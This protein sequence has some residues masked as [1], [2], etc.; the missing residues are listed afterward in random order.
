PFPGTTPLQLAM[1]HT[2][3]PPVLDPLPGPER[4]AIA[5]ALAKVPEQR[6]AT[7]R[8]LAEKLQA[9]PT[10]PAGRRPS[11]AAL[12]AALPRS[13]SA[14]VATALGPVVSEE[15]MARTTSVGSIPLTREA[16]APK[17]KLP[18]PLP[19]EPELEEVSL[20]REWTE[21]SPDPSIG[22]GTLGRRLRPT[23]YVGL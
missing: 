11:K 18:T 12:E 19:E 4:P 22:P 3:S 6:F 9:A 8:E 21:A 7:C 10:T 15:I 14:D 17:L 5:K 20:P 1:Q 13:P 16:T 2:H 23:L